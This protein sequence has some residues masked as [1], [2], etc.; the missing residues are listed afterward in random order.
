MFLKAGFGV[1]IFAGLCLCQSSSHPPVLKK[2]KPTYTRQAKS[3]IDLPARP[4]NS[5]ADGQLSQLEKE[6]AQTI[7][8]TAKSAQQP[9]LKTAAPISK[10]AQTR[11]SIN[12]S[13]QQRTTGHINTGTGVRPK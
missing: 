12:F 10:P 4:K 3:S 8:S 11:G 9:A 6:T 13:Y 2:A 1:F 5:S 7:S